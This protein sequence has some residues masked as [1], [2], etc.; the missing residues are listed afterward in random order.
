MKNIL[1]YGDS[2]TY[3]FDPIS[4]TRFDRDKRWT[5]ILAKELGD[6]YHIIEEGLNHRTTVWDDPILDFRNGKRYLV[7]CLHSHKPIDLVILMLGSN[8]LK[9]RFRL[10]ASDI[11]DGISELANIILNSGAGIEGKSPELLI[12]SE[13]ALGNITRYAEMMEGA[14]EKAGKLPFYYEKVAEDMN[15]HFLNMSASIQCSDADGLH[16]EA[17]E[18]N[19]MAQILKD[20]ILEIL[21]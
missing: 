18:Q 7:P 13:P 16:M 12:L 19:K 4:E 15:C 10:S 20:K 9:A 1:C 11:A 17:E 21:A 5:G 14:E 8:D 2:N 6:M 3:G